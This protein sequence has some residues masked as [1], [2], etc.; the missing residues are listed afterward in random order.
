MSPSEFKR[1]VRQL[2]L[3]LSQSEMA[4]ILEH[5]DDNGDGRV[6]YDEFAHF[7]R[8]ACSKKSADKERKDNA[9]IADRVREALR[10]LV[11]QDGRSR[12]DLVRLFERFDRGGEGY[13][14]RRDFRKLVDELGPM[15]LTDGELDALLD[16][17]DNRRKDGAVSY[18]E[19]VRFVQTPAATL[20][21]GLRSPSKKRRR[22]EELALVEEKVKATLKEL[23]EV[24]E[25]QFNIRRA[26][27]EFDVNATGLVT[28][29]EF[30]KCLRALGFRLRVDEVKALLAYFDRNRDGKISYPEFVAFFKSES[31][32]AAALLKGQGVSKGERAFARK[33]RD[34][35]SARHRE[36]VTSRE[37]VIEIG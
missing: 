8:A 9:V 17:F 4:T 7:F 27:D 19:F 37:R 32:A 2:G 6:K 31:H 12:E 28:K 14:T 33:T 16:A 1:G 11:R 5:F 24:G 13:L 3:D 23:S 20:S 25:G 29:A 15:P 10:A 22:A 26:F 21:S 30:E 18:R 34:I 36:G 35:E